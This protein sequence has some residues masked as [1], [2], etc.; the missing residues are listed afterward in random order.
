[1]TDKHYHY[2]QPNPF[3]LAAFRVTEDEIKLNR[4]G[5][6]SQ[7]QRRR[8]WLDRVPTMLSA[9]AFW[10]A[11]GIIYSIFRAEAPTAIATQCLG[12]LLIMALIGAIGVIVRAWRIMSTLTTSVATG[13]AK[14][15]ERTDRYGGLFLHL[16][17]RNFELK[18]HQ[19]NLLRD[20]MTLA[21]YYV[22]YRKRVLSVELIVFHIPEDNI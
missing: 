9:I 7:I 3:W 16:D 15:D 10:L 2:L 1:M 13:V 11:T 4:A 6:L 19:F 8:L 17:G 14:L 5:Q 21:V 20:N 22:P 18:R 12:I